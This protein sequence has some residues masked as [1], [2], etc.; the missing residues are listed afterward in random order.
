MR[1]RS[2]VLALILSGFASLT[3][4]AS[5]RLTILHSNDVHGLSLIHI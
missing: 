5:Q 2:I 1:I 3:G 4:A